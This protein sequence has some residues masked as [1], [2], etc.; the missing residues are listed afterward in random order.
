MDKMI[1]RLFEDPERY[2]TLYQGCGVVVVFRALGFG[3]GGLL[4]GL[5][6]ILQYFVHLPY[7][8]SLRVFL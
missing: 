7:N 6:K 2:P 3:M 8:S 4:R 5:D 1:A